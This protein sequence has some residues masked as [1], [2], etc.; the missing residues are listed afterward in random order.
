MRL[1]RLLMG[2]ALAGLASSLFLAP[3]QASAPEYVALGDSYSSGTGAGSYT[4]LLCTRSANAYPA[5]L[6]AGRPGTT[7]KFVACGGATIPDVVADQLSALSANT[8]LVTISIGGNDAG[9]AN[10]MLSCKYSTTTQCRSALEEGQEFV[11][12]ELP[13]KLDSLYSQ[14]R[15]RA[16]QAEVVVVGY[17]HLYKQG[18]LCLGG[19]GSTKR[20][21][22]NAASDVLAEVLA[23]RAAA[24]GFTFADA[25]P[26]FAGH[27]ICTADEWIDASNVHPTATGHA[28]GYLPVVTAAEG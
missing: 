14:I 10:T 1:F 8:T 26:G 17:P 20:D 9:F 23:S 2:T 19:L 28:R 6:A 27:E 15:S 7:F 12:E 24:A 21:M 22:I 25:R 18:G 5:L 16:P 11:R 3:A 13:A 4:N